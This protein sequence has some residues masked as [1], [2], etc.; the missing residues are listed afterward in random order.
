[1]KLNRR[2][3]LLKTGT[4]AAAGMLGG[5]L[6]ARA[7]AAATNPGER[8]VSLIRDPADPVANA[9]AARWAPGGFVRGHRGPRS[10]AGRRL[11]GGAA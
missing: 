8:G 1:M 4:V 5:T 6:V 10:R 7:A 2:E 9:P 11:Q 3:F